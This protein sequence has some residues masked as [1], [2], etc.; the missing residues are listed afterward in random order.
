MLKNRSVSPRK[1]ILILAYAVLY[2]VWGST[3]L[4][5]RFSVETIP[6]FFSGGIR[7]LTAGTIL[8]TFRSLQT[9]KK[10]TL[11]NWKHAYV[12]GQLPFTITYGALTMAELVVPSSI[13]AL[14]VAL[15]PL[16]FCIIGWLCYSGPKPTAAN[17]FA[18]MLGFAGTALLVIGD[19]GANFSMNSGYIIWVLIIFLSTFT[20]VFGAFVSRNPNIHE[21]SLMA[22]G[23][24]MLSGG[25][26]MMMIQLVISLVTG[27]SVDISAISMR[28]AGALAYLILFGSIITY[29]SFIWLMRIEPASRVSTHTFVNPIVAIFLGWALGGETIHAGM[30]MGAPLIITSVVLMVW[31][32]CLT[33]RAKAPSG[34][35]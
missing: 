11:S 26:T 15:E 20:W 12:G 16:W 2:I 21:D 14:I 28:S 6:P 9:G 22:S 13:T 31:N 1:S 29:S 18:L 10:T 35:D 32:P 3:Y 30:L 8:F 25:A 33:R 34:R 19:P 27:K 7:F 23:M 5:I 4:A 17:Y 24:Q